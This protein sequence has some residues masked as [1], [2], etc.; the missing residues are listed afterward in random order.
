[1][2]ALLINLDKATERMAFQKK[3]LQNLGIKYQRIT[4]I[5][6][7]SLKRRTYNKYYTTWERPLRYSEVACFLSHLSA[8]ELIISNQEP[9]LVLEDDALLSKKTPCLLDELEKSD[10]IDFVSLEVRGRKKTIAKHATHMICG[11]SMK[12][13]YQDRTGA[14]GYVLWPEGAKKLIERTRNGN[15]ALT[16]AFI[17]S[18]YQLR[19]FQVE[20]ATIIQ[21]DQCHVYGIPCPIKIKSFIASE[22]KPGSSDGIRWTYR[23]KRLLGQLKLGLRQLSVLHKSERKIIEIADDLK[24]HSV[25]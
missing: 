12:I 14:A 8:W 24:N 1:M 11:L 25:Q 19:A 2:R 23:L 17:S 13:L 5:S 20:P 15:I 4:A 3:Q 16:D 10:D 6:T 22:N 9:M 21:L 7:D 18:C